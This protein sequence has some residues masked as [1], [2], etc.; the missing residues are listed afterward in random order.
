M[1]TLPSNGRKAKQTKRVFFF[2]ESNNLLCT[3]VWYTGPQ[4]NARCSSSK[5][6]TSNKVLRN[7][8]CC[9]VA[10]RE[11]EH[12][13]GLSKSLSWPISQ[14]SCFFFF[15]PPSF[16]ASY[17]S[18]SP[19]LSTINTPTISSLSFFFFFLFSSFEC[20]RTCPTRFILGLPKNNAV[21]NSLF[22]YLIVAFLQLYFFRTLFLFT[23]L[24]HTAFY[25]V[26]FVCTVVVLFRAFD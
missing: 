3:P 7:D 16:S 20:R 2:C 11:K 10:F 5:M 14:L 21:L 13:A 17:L 4:V 23:F 1:V 15:L 22:F 19:S 24:S 8:L 25:F 12:L 18:F 26:C 9:A 6:P